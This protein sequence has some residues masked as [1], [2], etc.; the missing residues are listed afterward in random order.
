MTL[1]LYP[2]VFLPVAAALRRTD[3]ALEETRGAL[4]FGPWATFARVVL[5]QIR[6]G[7]ARREPGG[8][9]RPAGR[10]RSFE[11]LDFRTF[12][13]EIFTELQV[14]RLPRRAVPGAGSAGH[15]GR[16]RGP[17]RRSG[18]RQSRCRQATGHRCD[19]AWALAGPALVALTTL[20][21]SPRP[22]RRDDGLLVPSPH[23]TLPA[24]ATLLWATFTTRYSAEAAAV[25]TP[26]AAPVALLAA[27]RRGRLAAGLERSTYLVQ[28]VPGVV[29]ALSLVFF[30]VRYALALPDQ[31]AAGP[32]TRC[33]SSPWRW[34][35]SGPQ[36]CRP[37]PGLPR[38][39]APLGSG[40]IRA[41]LRV[42]LPFIAPGSGRIVLP[43][44]L[45]SVTELHRHPRPG[46]D[47]HPDPG[48][49]FWAYQ[50]NTAY[51]AAAPYAAMIIVIAACRACSG[52]WFSSEP[53]G[54]R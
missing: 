7:R 34:Y 14:D 46:S 5:P 15:P 26:A 37:R 9:V 29:M 8:H 33:C 10:V 48:H 32:P 42:T 53:G 18:A 30:S 40:P 11:I 28:S 25:A 36:R 49:Q 19:W 6:A 3:P 50:T 52:H 51:G 2:L 41:F 13:T 44:F 38:W 39:D 47:R 21:G 23:T 1:D 22:T 12:T 20:V 24:S 54:P 35:V 31:R 16:D 4:G 45:S 27:Q 43:G 17:R